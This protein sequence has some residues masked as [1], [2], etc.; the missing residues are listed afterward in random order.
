M[1]SDSAKKIHVASFDDLFGTEDDAGTG[2]IQNIPL[3]QL[4]SFQGH[5]FHVQDDDEMRELAA[6]IKEYGVLSPGIARPN[7]FG[8]G[9]EVISGHRRRYAC[10]LA[11]LQEMPFLIQDIGD[12]EATVVMVD[13]NLQREN[14]LPSEK[15]YAYKMK[16]EA[17]SHQGK[18]AETATA[19]AVGEAGGDS[20]RTVQRYIRLTELSERLL[21]FVDD[22]R[23]SLGAGEALSYLK[24]K[25]QEWLEEAVDTLNIYPSAAQAAMLKAAS[26]AGRLMTQESMYAFLVKKEHKAAAKITLPQKKL[27]TYFPDS[28]TTEQMEE[29]I[30]R[31]L[32]DWSNGK[33]G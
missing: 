12:D 8:D 29:I 32:D 7:R 10:E 1:K 2:R 28:Y 15:A 25:E 26:S 11:G 21:S 3:T 18:K 9:Y 22:G 16:F 24:Q 31:L 20:G 4:H 13:A 33:E 30:Y 23:I 27:H 6:S 5:P 14:I 17:L 19:E